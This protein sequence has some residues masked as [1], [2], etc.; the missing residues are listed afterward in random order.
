MLEALLEAPLE[1]L[2]FDRDCCALSYRLLEAK[3][4]TRVYRE[5][6]AGLA[7]KH[8]I[9][10][11]AVL[12]VGNDM[13]N[14]IWPAAEVGCRTALFAGDERSLRLRRDDPRCAGVTPDRIVTDLSQITTGL[15][16]P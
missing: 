8:G 15:L 1:A 10:P 9:P 4:S 6:L 14:D 2:G 13:R 16:P 5:A 7:A 11:G 3:P 12:Y